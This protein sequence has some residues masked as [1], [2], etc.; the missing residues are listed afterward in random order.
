ML[1]AIQYHSM[2]TEKYIDLCCQQSST[3]ACAQR[4]QHLCTLNIGVL[5]HLAQV[6]HTFDVFQRKQF[7]PFHICTNSP[8]KQLCPISHLTWLLSLTTLVP[9]DQIPHHSIVSSWQDKTFCR[10]LWQKNRQRNRILFLFVAKDTHPQ[11]N[12]TQNNS[13]QH[14]WLQWNMK[15]RYAIC[16]LSVSVS[17]FLP[18]SLP[19]SSLSLCVEVPLTCNLLCIS[20]PLSASSS[21][22]PSLSLSCSPHPLCLSLSLSL[23]VS[24]SLCT[25]LL[26][27]NLLSISPFSSSSSMLLSLRMTSVRL[28]VLCR[29]SRVSCSNRH[30]VVSDIWGIDKAA[31]VGLKLPRDLAQQGQGSAVAIHRSGGGG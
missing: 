4:T 17:L 3:T 11:K 31:T 6:L 1:S 29:F 22:S 13:L 14:S 16:S 26:T 30:V 8:P 7:H 5:Q 21:R 24:L 12:T 9:H 10:D 20:L 23:S 15:H 18:L 25:S 28:V 2:C 27:C 19:P